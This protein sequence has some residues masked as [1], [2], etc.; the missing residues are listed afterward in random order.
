[1]SKQKVLLTSNGNDGIGGI[2]GRPKKIIIKKNYRELLIGRYYSRF[3]NTHTISSFE[4]SIEEIGTF[5]KQYMEGSHCMHLNY[6]LQAPCRSG[7]SWF[8]LETLYKSKQLN[9]TIKLLVFVVPHISKNTNKIGLE[10]K[11]KEFNRVCSETYINIISEQDCEDEDYLEFILSKDQLNILVTT[12]SKIYGDGSNKKPIGNNITT[13]L[14]ENEIIWMIDEIHKNTQLFSI[15]SKTGKGNESGRA[16][17]PSNLF[18][19]KKINE[20]IRRS[21]VVGMTATAKEI[22]YFNRM[23]TENNIKIMPISHQVESGSIVDIDGDQQIPY[24]L[25]NGK[26]ITEEDIVSTIAEHYLPQY[27]IS[28]KSQCII[29]SSNNTNASYIQ[30]IINDKFPQLYNIIWTSET[31]KKHKKKHD[32]DGIEDF[33]EEEEKIGTY[34]HIII[35]CRMLTDSVTIKNAVCMIQTNPMSD[36]GSSADPEPHRSDNSFQFMW[37]GCNPELKSIKRKNII[38]VKDLKTKQLY[39]RNKTYEC[40]ALP[41]YNRFYNIYKPLLNSYYI[42]NRFI[43]L[44]FIMRIQTAILQ[45]LVYKKIYPL[46]CFTNEMEWKISQDEINTID[47]Y[48]HHNKDSLLD[49]CIAIFEKY[50]DMLV[51]KYKD[52]IMTHMED[53]KK[54]LLGRWIYINDNLSSLGYSE[55]NPEAKLIIN[56]KLAE[57]INPEI[58]GAICLLDWTSFNT[59]KTIT[60]KYPVLKP[61]LIIPQLNNTKPEQTDY[62]HMVIDPEF[63]EYVKKGSLIDIVDSIPKI[64]TIYADFCGTWETQIEQ[65]DFIEK[66]LPKLSKGS[67]LAITISSGMRSNADGHLLDTWH[68]FI[69]KKR[70]DLEEKIEDEYKLNTKALKFNGERVYFYGDKMH[71]ATF[72]IQCK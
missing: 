45:S 44:Y 7:K 41:Q 27:T 54:D 32:V 65:T 19:I 38:F 21:F 39:L 72:I 26:N 24:I 56:T 50:H 69:S 16:A 8:G 48:I 9:T 14:Q 2:D 31:A 43:E 6:I 42:N 63:G 61:R 58:D 33:L 4:S 49:Q 23:Y 60:E 57:K 20:F 11:L 15:F 55:S 34:Y 12:P 25:K 10:K 17:E 68:R 62:T 51:E 13:I 64:N 1:M 66:I 5:Y 28:N 30:T 18:K 46:N 52:E 47:N 59:S 35:H 70:E 71:M 67:L 22:L 36:A 3:C 53:I 40:K 29:S 37:R